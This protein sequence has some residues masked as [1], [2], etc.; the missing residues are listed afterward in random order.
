M[1]MPALPNAAALVLA[2]CASLAFAQN[3]VAS[4]PSGKGATTI[5]RQTMPDGEIVYSDKPMKGGKIDRIIKVEPPIRGNTWTTAPSSGSS[6]PRIE[7][8]SERKKTEAEADSDVIRAE[9]LLEDAKKRRQSGVEPLP[10][11]RTGNASGGSRLNQA[12]RDRQQAL[13]QNVDAAEAALQ[14]AVAER[15]A[16][17]GER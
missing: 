15:D 4:A 12:Y 8:S 9:M 2:C 10:G 17:R 13:T 7:S 1:K 14:K 5:Y 6:T 11:E 3:M 16:L